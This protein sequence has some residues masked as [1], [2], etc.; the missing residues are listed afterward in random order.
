MRT[1][2]PLVNS[3]FPSNSQTNGAKWCRM[4][5]SDFRFAT[6]P[7]PAQSEFRHLMRLDSKRGYTLPRAVGTTPEA[8]VYCTLTAPYP[9]GSP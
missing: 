8:Q 3:K 7:P 1:Y 6:Y 2:P 4:V 9:G 5:Q